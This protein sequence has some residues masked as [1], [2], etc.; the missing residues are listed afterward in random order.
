MAEDNKKKQT[1]LIAFGQGIKS[2]GR[3]YIPSGT[4]HV[5]WRDVK[6]GFHPKHWDKIESK[7]WMEKSGK[8]FAWYRGLGNYEGRN[9]SQLLTENKR[10]G[11][12]KG[13]KTHKNITTRT[14]EQYKGSRPTSKTIGKGRE[15]QVTRHFP[16]SDATSYFEHDRFKATQRKTTWRSSI[17]GGKA[18]RL[19]TGLGKDRFGIA[20][21]E[22]K[23]YGKG[24]G[25]KGNVGITVDP[26]WSK[27]RKV[28]EATSK[29]IFPKG[30]AAVSY[31]DRAG[32]IKPLI[33]R[34]SK[35]GGLI[36][37]KNTVQLGK[38]AKVAAKGFGR[39]ATGASGIGTAWMTYD[40]V[41]TSFEEQKHKAPTKKQKIYGMD[42]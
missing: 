17:R 41:K 7:K 1:G 12:S 29:Y 14:Y 34:G 42:V 23:K 2:F 35:L 6:K 18:A 38:M 20:I 10:R 5:E 13:G 37:S 3:N 27:N 16:A 36:A 24:I 32:N 15:W 4:S 40:L 30:P 28:F 33:A 19:Q 11:W 26:G 9:K 31:L 39:L 22:T 21:K 8:S 25:Y